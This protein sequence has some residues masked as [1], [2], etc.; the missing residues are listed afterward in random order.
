MFSNET[1]VSTLI[2]T[3]GILVCVIFWKML[4]DKMYNTKMRRWVG[5]IGLNPCKKAKDCGDGEVCYDGVCLT[6]KICKAPSDKVQVQDCATNEKC[7]SKGDIGYCV[8]IKSS[9]S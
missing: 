5:C 1:L 9:T 2:I 4:D 7:I 8:P 3:I 6:R